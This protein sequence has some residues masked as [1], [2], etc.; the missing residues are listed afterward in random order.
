MG[1]RGVFVWTR[2]HIKGALVNGQ[3]QLKPAMAETKAKTGP[4]LEGGMDMGV[5]YA[6][7]EQYVAGEAHDWR[8]FKFPTMATSFDKEPRLGQ[9]KS[10]GGSNH[11]WAGTT[12]HSARSGSNGTLANDASPTQKRPR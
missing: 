12:T 5:G 8:G 7:R 2:R 11:R 4:E 9:P 3:E 6:L 10:R 1:W